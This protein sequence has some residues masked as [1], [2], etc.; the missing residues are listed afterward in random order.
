MVRLC[1]TIVV[2]FLI[3]AAFAEEDSK[4]LVLTES[5]FQN[6]ITEN[7]IVLV[8]FCTFLSVPI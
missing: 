6:T 8:D 7:A 5:N 3:V 4:V 1:T 2:T